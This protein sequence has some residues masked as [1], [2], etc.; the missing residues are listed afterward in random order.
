MSENITLLLCY[1]Y[2]KTHYIIPAWVNKIERAFDLAEN[3]F[4]QIPQSRIRSIS[5]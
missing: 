3:L 1:E 4:I 2:T 5:P